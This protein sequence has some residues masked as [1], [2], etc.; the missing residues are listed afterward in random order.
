MST[1][2][3]K[4]LK[5]EEFEVIKHFKWLLLRIAVTK[6][7]KHRH[8]YTTWRIDNG[9]WILDR[10]KECDAELIF[11]SVAD[12]RKIVRTMKTTEGHLIKTLERFSIIAFPSAQHDGHRKWIAQ[13]SKM[14]Y[15]FDKRMTPAGRIGKDPTFI[16]VKKTPAQAPTQFP[17]QPSKKIEFTDSH[18]KLFY[19]DSEWVY[20]Q[21]GNR[22]YK[23]QIR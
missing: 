20:D 7:Q 13:D 19:R 6:V 21:E 8:W 4:D 3:R 11:V 18:G 5:A 2:Y 23:S 22:L 9:V 17:P 12:L 15:A 10:L 1:K 14:F 16:P